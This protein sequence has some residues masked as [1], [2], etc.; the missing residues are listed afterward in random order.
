MLRQFLGSWG[1]SHCGRLESTGPISG[2][3]VLGCS[4][5]CD[6]EAQPNISGAFSIS[7]EPKNTDFFVNVKEFEFSMLET[8][9]V[10]RNLSRQKITNL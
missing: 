6:R 2:Q 1:A 8:D 10:E 3:S 4:H 7:V 9:L 5:C